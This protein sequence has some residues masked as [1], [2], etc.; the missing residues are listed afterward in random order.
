MKNLLNLLILLSVSSFNAQCWQKN[1][2]EF[3]LRNDG[4]LWKFS[5]AGYFQDL[6]VSQFDTDGDW[7]SISQKA[8]VLA[9][10]ENGTLWAWGNNFFGQMGNGQAGFDN[11]IND[12]AMIGTDTDW[13]YVCAGNVSSFALKTDGS[14]WGWGNNSIGQLGIGS[15][16]NM[17][18]PTKIGEASYITVTS[19]YYNT[20]AIRN[21]GTLWAWG[22][23]NIGQLG[24]GDLISRSV[25]TQIGLDSDWVS[26]KAGYNHVV[27]LK[28]NGTIWAWGS[29]N[30]GQLGDGTNI[31]KMSPIQ[32]PI[33]SGWTKIAASGIT[34]AVIGGQIY[35]S[36]SLA[37]KSDGTLWGWGKLGSG[38]PATAG[39]YLFTTSPVQLA[40]G[41]PNI[42]NLSDNDTEYM[43]TDTNM[44]LISKL[45][46]WTSAMQ[47]PC[48]ELSLSPNDLDTLKIYP[49]PV[50]NII[51]ITLPHSM[52]GNPEYVLYNFSG[53]A[54]PLKSDNG[55]I[56]I[57]RF[58]SGVYALEIT[59]DS[60]IFH[61][62][63]IKN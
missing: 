5:Y 3:G 38:H 25:P 23:N 15:N 63:I 6:T 42:N 13:A 29:N 48:V 7:Q 46:D 60:N 62:K 19:G 9:L 22:Y 20:F 58:E 35:N 27:A 11:Y 17:L 31:N 39:T 37:I 59:I 40:V 45:S 32:V 14:L 1:S 33:G 21:D 54:V 18:V 47:I 51:T 50:N 16:V 10:K 4:T 43:A 49:N 28:S 53:K 44:Y 57:S 56:D 36:T 30:N 52:V 26:V 12:P 61:K 55:N 8:S 34:F 24:T 41:I 2:G